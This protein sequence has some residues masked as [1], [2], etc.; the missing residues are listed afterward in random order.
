MRRVFGPEK[1][2]AWFRESMCLVLNQCVLGPEF[3]CAWFRGNVSLVPSF[4]VLGPEG[5]SANLASPSLVRP[6]GWL[7]NLL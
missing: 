5:L 1:V 2:C 6:V 7:S 4:R 3:P